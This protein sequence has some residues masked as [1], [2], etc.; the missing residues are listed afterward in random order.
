MSDIRWGVAKTLIRH[1]SRYSEILPDY[2]L[3]YLKS[4][5]KYED[6]VGF[7]HTLLTCLAILEGNGINDPAIT[8]LAINLFDSNHDIFSGYAGG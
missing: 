4:A 2:T 7:W 6:G 5:A 1:I 8:A 3:V